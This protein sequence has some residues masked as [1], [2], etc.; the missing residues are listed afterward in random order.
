MSTLSLLW[1]LLDLYDFTFDR[2]VH[3]SAPYNP[4]IFIIFPIYR[5]KTNL[6]NF[7]RQYGLVTTY[8]FV[9]L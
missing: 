6:Y 1:I 7:E 8:N 2:H 3:F 5:F 4:K 9:K